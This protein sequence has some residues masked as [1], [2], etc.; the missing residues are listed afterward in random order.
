MV[1]E[2]VWAKAN[3]NF[4]ADWPQ[5]MSLLN[6]VAAAST[7][8][9]ACSHIPTS[10]APLSCGHHQIIL[11]GDRGTGCKQPAQ[12]YCIACP[13]RQYWI[14]YLYLL[15]AAPP[16]MA[17]ANFV[18]ITNGGGARS[19][20]QLISTNS[21]PC[22]IFP[23]VAIGC[24]LSLKI[25][26]NLEGSLSMATW[27]DTAWIGGTASGTSYISV[28]VPNQK[29]NLWPMNCITMPPVK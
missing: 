24:R 26:R 5:A 12:R 17:A 28:S 23:R 1:S 3:P 29:W 10:G 21:M 20:E 13:Q 22:A 16:Y 18:V 11:L 19:L 8:C 2:I 25:D 6:P 4:Y 14:E 7:L 15:L 27:D 9:Y